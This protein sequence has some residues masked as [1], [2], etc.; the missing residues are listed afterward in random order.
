MTPRAD[1]PRWGRL[2]DA[3]RLMAAPPARQAA[4]LPELSEIADQIR[5]GEPQVELIDV[6]LS[7]EGVLPAEVGFLIQRIDEVFDGLVGEDPARV[8]TRSALAERAEWKL[9]RALAGEALQQ[10]GV[11]MPRA[12]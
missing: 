4:M 6:T 9:M 12:I 1:D 3:L 10:L 8:F 2:V 5:R 7:R 11:P